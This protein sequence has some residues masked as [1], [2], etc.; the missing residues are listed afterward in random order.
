MA[1]EG[2]GQ[3]GRRLIFKYLPLTPALS[4]NLDFN[5]MQAVLVYGLHSRLVVTTALILTFSPRRRD[6]DCMRLFTRLHVVRIQSRVLY[7]SRV[8]GANFFG[9]FSPRLAGRGSQ[10]R[11]TP[12]PENRQC[13]NLNLLFFF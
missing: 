13:L 2:V 11:N 7:G 10:T 5:G 6:N 4:M 3:G 8:Q 1:D 9:E 12:L